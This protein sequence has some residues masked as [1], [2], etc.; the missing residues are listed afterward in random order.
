MPGAGG[1]RNEENRNE[2]TNQWRHPERNADSS[3]RLIVW[4]AATGGSN[5]EMEMK[6]DSM[7]YI[8]VDF[9]NIA[10]ETVSGLPLDQTVYIFAGEK[11]SKMRMDLVESML[12]RGSGAKLIR[13]NGDGKNALDFHIA[14]YLGK[15]SSAE[16]KASF[17]IL[18]KDKGFDALINH[19]KIAKVNCE[20][21][22][23]LVQKVPTKIDLKAKIRAFS[24]HLVGLPEKS[25]PKK[26]SKLKAYLK[27]WAKKDDSIVDPVFNGLVSGKQIEIEGE[28]IKYTG[29]QEI[30]E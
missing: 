22:E 29:K 16:Q 12:S 14:Y 30:K 11:Q 7:E 15:L 9:E 20:R 5:E 17:K 2:N 18:S 4:P 13:I 23:K 27:N 24:L 6:A 8:F 10:P 26:V 1:I 28:K 3:G 25:R 19:L 21:I